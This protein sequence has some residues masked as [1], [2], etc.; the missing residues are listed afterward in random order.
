[1]M[2][3]PLLLAVLALPFAACSSVKNYELGLHGEQQ[4]NLNEDNQ[5]NDVRVKVLRLKGDEAAKA[6]LQAPFDALWSEPVSAENVAVDGAA[7]TIYV[8][9]RD[10]RVVLQLKEVQPTVT[11]IGVLGLF[12]SPVTGKDRIV[13]PC[14]DLGSVDVWLHG[15]TLTTVAPTAAAPTAADKQGS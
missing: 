12:N 15:N 5:P 13:L 7:Q 10:E 1:M 9:H 2:R 4:L 11:H 8:R 14:A 3:A 6:F